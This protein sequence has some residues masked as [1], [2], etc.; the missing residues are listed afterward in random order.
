MARAFSYVVKRDFG[1][2][3]NPFYGVLTLATCKQDIR[4][5][6]VVGDFI[7]GNADSTHDYKLIYMAKVSEILTF[8]EYWNDERFQCKKPVMNGSQKKLYGDNVYH[9]DEQGNW[10]Q[11][12]SHHTNEDGSVNKHNLKR[13]TETSDH[14][15]ICNEFVYFG[16]SMVDISG[17]YDDCLRKHIGYKCPD[18]NRAQQLWDYLYELYPDGGKID[19]PTKF[20]QFER[21]DGVS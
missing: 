1:F 14:V 7:I 20:L 4:K 19:Q 9:H 8:D 6:A 5:G 13:D 2:A 17:E 21:Y 16:K 3:P 11:E 12:N 18:Y 10:V 15:L